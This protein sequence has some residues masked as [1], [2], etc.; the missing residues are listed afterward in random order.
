[1]IRQKAAQVFHFSR[2]DRVGALL[3]LIT[4]SGAVALSYYGDTSHPLLVE[5]ANLLT[6]VQADTALNRFSAPDLA[7][8]QLPYEMNLP[9]TGERFPFDPNTA[10]A[11]EWQRLGLS[12]RTTRTILNYRSKGGRFYKPEDLK[13]IWGLQQAFFESVK[14]Y[15]SIPEP[16]TRWQ[17][18]TEKA[19]S[20]PESKISDVDINTS[21]SAAW[22]QLPGIGP[23]YS[24][25]IV[26]FREK[27]GGFH[28][29]EQVSE[30][31]GL[32]DS[33][34]Q[35]IKSHLKFTPGSVRQIN[36]NSA[37]KDQ[38]R[39]HP[40]ISWNVANAIVEYRNQH[41]QYQSVEELKKIVV[42]DDATLKKILPYLSL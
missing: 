14:D 1:M 13:K 20:R 42:L 17:Q 40:Y 5:E 31:Y 7:A 15:I 4:V 23:A 41:G 38:L 28:S 22:R 37:T 8:R 24:A 27:L 6:Q 11:L 32:P 39:A 25:R 21:D 34:F 30:T 26:K 9:K 18:N 3:I 2:R 10:T 29:I 35:K 36:I 33:T 12:Q 16:T 19:F